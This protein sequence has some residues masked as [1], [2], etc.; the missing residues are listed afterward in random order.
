MVR[1]YLLLTGI[2]GIIILVMIS[3]NQ[4]ILW[5][6]LV[7]SFA[8]IFIG[9]MLGQLYAKNA[10]LEIGFSEE[11]FYMRSAYD[12]A[13]QK[14]LRL[15]PILYANATRYGDTIMLNYIEQNVKIR[16]GE[17]QQWDELWYNWHF[18]S[19]PEV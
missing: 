2:F 17:W 9:N 11:Y 15:Y 10:F 1:P 16:R 4:S 18:Y 3:R 8:I 6:G 19:A 12:I 5:V 14:D 13:Y 7:G